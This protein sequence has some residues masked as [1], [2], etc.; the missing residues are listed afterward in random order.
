MDRFLLSFTGFC[1]V[2]LG[3]TVFYW[4]LLGFTGFYWVLL[5]FT[6]FYWV[7]LGFTEFHRILSGLIG[8]YWVLLG[9]IGFYWVLLGFTGF[10]WVLLG[11]TGFYWVLL[12]LTNF[13]SNLQYLAG[14]IGIRD[15]KKSFLYYPNYFFQILLGF[16]FERDAK[17]VVSASAEF[18]DVELSHF[19]L[20]HRVLP[21]F[22]EFRH[23]TGLANVG[24][25]F[26]S[27]GFALGSNFRPLIRATRQPSVAGPLRDKRAFV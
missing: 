26:H 2:L 14:S 17:L 4:I 21:C 8:L 24:S 18:K 23:S 12:E 3:F 10:Y 20:F 27:N 15:P 11:F 9:F 5:G 13:F 1:Q 19:V 16:T 25:R 7:L 22:T 6:G